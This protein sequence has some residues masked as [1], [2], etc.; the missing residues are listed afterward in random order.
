MGCPECQHEN[1]PGAKFCDECGCVMPRLWPD[2]SI[3]S[4]ATEHA[5]PKRQPTRRGE[6]AAAIGVVT[7]GIAVIAGI[8][9]ASPGWQRVFAS[10]Q[11]TPAARIAEQSPAPFVADASRAQAPRAD[12]PEAPRSVPVAPN[13]STAL[14]PSGV[15]PQPTLAPPPQLAPAMPQPTPR[16]PQ[17]APPA[18]QVAAPAPQVAPARP[19]FAPLGPAR[20]Q[21]PRS[22]ERAQPGA[23]SDTAQVMASLLVT[24]LGQDPAWRTA[25]ANADAHAPESPE[26]A[27]WR[28]VAQAI[29]DG[30][31]RGPR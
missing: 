29:R 15:P 11:E 9:I 18:P 25:L 4:F 30:G 28:K 24:Q 27:Y 6:I 12:G 14:A 3:I 20:G 21:G 7:T 26:H 1:R 2:A 23:A 16:P 5:R 22:A 17:A 19:P 13:F 10:W 31:H 8:V